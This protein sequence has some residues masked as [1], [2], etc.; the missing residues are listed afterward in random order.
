VLTVGVAVTPPRVV[1][2]FVEPVVTPPGVWVI[3]DVFDGVDVV[4]G[5]VVFG[6]LP[7]VTVLPPPVGVLG[8]FGILFGLYHG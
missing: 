3:V 5:A 4:A 8:L 7:T 6:W 2:V 1:V